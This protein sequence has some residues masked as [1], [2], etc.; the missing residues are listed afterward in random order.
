MN[1]KKYYFS[2]LRRLVINGRGQILRPPKKAEF[3][4]AGSVRVHLNGG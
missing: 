1:K 3:R 2:K 4:N